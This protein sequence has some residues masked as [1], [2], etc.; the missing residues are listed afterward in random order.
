MLLFCSYTIYRWV[1]SVSVKKQRVFKLAFPF[2]IRRKNGDFVIIDNYGNS[3]SVKA[4]EVE[5]IYMK[6]IDSDKFVLFEVNCQESVSS[7]AA[8]GIDGYTLFHS[9]VPKSVSYGATKSIYEYYRRDRDLSYYALIKREGS[10]DRK[11]LLGS[12]LKPT[13]RMSQVMQVILQNF[14]VD[15]DFDRYLLSSVLPSS[16]SQRRMMKCFL[17]ILTFEKYLEMHEAKTGK[18]RQVELFRRTEKL[19]EFLISPRL[20]KKP[21]GLSLGQL[22]LTSD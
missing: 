21:N 19:R 20:R 16:L 15:V 8:A 17:D 13:S 3:Q 4:D 22:P 2:R 5:S 14:N 6:S 10:K 7:Q 18:G 9:S 12:M 11:F 1:K